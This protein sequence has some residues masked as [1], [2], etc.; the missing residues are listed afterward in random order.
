MLAR[1]LDDAV[2]SGDRDVEA[3]VLHNWGDTQFNAGQYEDALSKLE[4][5]AALFQE[6]D[7]RVSLGTVFNSLGRLYRAHGRLD[8]ALRFQMKALA[9]HEAS[10][11]SLMH[12]QSLNAVAAVDAM[13]GRTADARSFYEQAL[14]L[15]EKSES[16][17]VQDF[18]RANIAGQWINEGKFE[19]GAAALEQVIA[20]NVDPYPSQRYARLSF[21]YLRL[22]RFE[23]ARSAAE[24]AVKLCAEG[25]SDCVRALGSRAA[26]R[27]AL[28]QSSAALMDIDAALGLLEDIRKKLV[29]TDYFKQDFQN[30]QQSTYSQAI[31]LKV[32][33]NQPAASLETAELARSRA[34]IDLLATRDV[35]VTASPASFAAVTAV[36]K[37]LQSTLVLYWVA[38]NELFIWVV[39]PDG[40]IRVERVP[41]RQSKLTELIRSTSPFSDSPSTPTAKGTEWRELY[42]LLIKP[43]RSALP[44]TPG[45]LITIVPAGPLLNLSFAA[46]QNERGRYL[47]EDYT[48]H[49]APAGAVLQFTEPKRRLDART[50]DVLLVADPTPP[51]LSRLDQPLARLPGARMETAAIARLLSRERLTQLSDKAATESAVRSATAGRAVIHLATHAI[52]RDDDP[53]GSFLAL[54]PAA[55]AKG[56]GILT[57]QQ[58][59]GWDLHADL[60]VLSACRSAGGRVTGDGIATFARAFI[61]AGAASLIASLWDVADEPTNRLLPDFYRSWLGG[62]SKARALRA[63][64]LRL[65]R[66]LRDGRIQIR[67]AAGMVTLPE[68]PVF[69]AGFALIGEP[70]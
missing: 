41:V 70:D 49:Y 21:A 42:D 36:A 5:A 47:L 67:T 52:V 32:G 22:G 53:F 2:A 23:P 57:A 64:Q 6:L 31:A 58:I 38:E 13:L 20:H 39:T 46:L 59:Y 66:D 50:S 43:V 1:A 51:V 14:A 4:R 69:W 11:N 62:Q 37:R 3:R 65:L 15:A 26:A 29:P 63:A 54:A 48:L 34:F 60:V 55:G 7:L 18:L 35:H 30:A 16:P 19:R 10:G 28:G 40:R 61:Y 44:A 56:D 17:R 68:H 33:L 8:E 9:L 24:Q 45:S 25:S 12:I 27:A